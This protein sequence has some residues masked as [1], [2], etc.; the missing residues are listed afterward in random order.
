MLAKIRQW[1]GPLLFVAILY[2]VELLDELSYGLHG[3]VLPFLKNDFALTYV[4]VGLL[5]TLPALIALIGD[6]IIGLLGDTRHRRALV[7]GGIAATAVGLWLTALSQTFGLILL[8]FCVLYIAS[9]AYVNLAQGTLIDLNPARAEQTMARWTLVGSIGVVVSPLILTVVFAAGSSWR[10]VYLGLA[11]V[12]GMY[13]LVLV[14]QRFD[15]HTGAQDESVSPR[16]LWRSLIAALR[17]RSLLRWLILTELADFMLDQLLEVTG[18][19]FHDVAGVSLAGAS[20]AVAV[21]AIAG[22]I[23]NALIVPAL[24]KVRGLRLIRVTAIIVLMAY[25]AM[26]ITSAVWLKYVL[27]AVISFSTAGWFAI[28]RAKCFELLPGQSGLV[29]AATSLVNVIG[30]F[31]PVILGGIADAIGLQAAMWL[32]AIGPVALIIGVR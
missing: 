22:L 25:A 30:L 31:V 26:L 8:S 13:T 32:L 24:E 7:V 1:R 21:F 3:A 16:K 20:G 6:P 29:I 15:A 14:R 12:A 2:A 23:G 9:G 19:Y 4:Q 28:L 5:S 18:L 11:V 27:I 10:G 17:N